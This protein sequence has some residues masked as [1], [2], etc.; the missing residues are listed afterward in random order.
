MKKSFTLIEILVV[1][2]VIGI[3]SAFILVGMSS[4]SSSANIAK[5]QAFA[6]SMRNSLL[7][8]LISEWKMDGNGNDSW[9]T[10]PGTTSTTTTITSGCVKNS[11][12]S[13]NGTDSYMQMVDSQ[14]LRMTTGGTISAW[15]YPKS[16]GENGAQ[17]I[18]D[19]STDAAATNGYLLYIDSAKLLGLY[20]N[21][22]YA[23][24]AIANTIS[25]NQWQLG[26]VT[27]NSSGRKIYVNGVDKTNT[28]GS[29]TMLPPD[30]AGSV[31][32]GQRAG[33]DDRTFD[34]YI[35][36]VSIYDVVFSTSQ[37]QEKY[38]SGLN[39]LLSNNSINKEEFVERISLLRSSI[40][41]N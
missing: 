11:C 16:A 39:R 36:E 33:A 23:T 40:G 41:E 37:I 25:Y 15:I 12:L 8:N 26:V 17:R 7:L 6:N 2:V 29:L 35:D 13:F 20:V 5:G 1:I 14:A 9:G 32:I 27:F 24:M 31:R 30:V 4:I 28:G 38:Y 10:N 34:G 21:G 18:I 3:L 19:K 22:G